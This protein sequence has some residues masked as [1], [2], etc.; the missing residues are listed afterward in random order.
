M[1]LGTHTHAR[2]YNIYYITL[3]CRRAAD[4]NLH[5][6]PLYLSLDDAFHD[7]FYPLSPS[8]PPPSSPQQHTHT[9]CPGVNPCHGHVG[10]V[11]YVFVNNIIRR[12]RRR[13]VA[14]HSQ[15][16]PPGRRV[17]G[18]C[19]KYYFRVRRPARVTT[20]SG[21]RGRRE[22]N[23]CTKI[24]YR[25]YCGFICIYIFIYVLTRFR[26]LLLL[27][28]SNTKSYYVRAYIVRVYGIVKRD[29]HTFDIPRC[30]AEFQFLE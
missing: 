29:F 15:K 5:V 25:S 23:N 16:I 22:V 19:C 3:W 12:R 6:P 2:I 24:K 20:R 4:N 28:C 18:G 27:L 13:C 1:C 21:G 30:P 14:D 11:Y 17:E 9:Q 26:V 7:Y 8:P 10:G